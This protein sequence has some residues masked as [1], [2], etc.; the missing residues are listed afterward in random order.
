MIHQ[1]SGGARGQATDIR[2]EADE[3]D[4]CKTSLTKILAENCNQPYEK[5]LKDCER[6]YYMSAQQALEYGMIDKVVMPTKRREH[7]KGDYWDTSK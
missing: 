1:P 4:Y 2:I 3:M 6:N 5:L 7:K